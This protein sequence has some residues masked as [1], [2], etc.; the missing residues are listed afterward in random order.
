VAQ[1]RYG[2]LPEKVKQ[3]YKEIYP[4]QKFDFTK[5]K[6]GVPKE[7]KLNRSLKSIYQYYKTVPGY[8]PQLISNK[9]TLDS[10]KT[11]FDKAIKKGPVSYTDLQNQFPAQASPTLEKALGKDFKKLTRHTPV[12]TKIKPKVLKIV[13]EVYA[14]KRPLIDAAPSRLYQATYG[15]P[16][17]M[18]T[19][20]MGTISGILDESDKYDKMRSKIKATVGRVGGGNKLFNTVK[21]KDFDKADIRTELPRTSGN[22]VEEN[23]LRDLDRYI[24]RGGKDFKYTPDGRTNKFKTLKIKD[25]KKGDVL[26]YDRIKELIKKRDPRFKEYK[27]VFDNMK[28]LK[29]APYSDPIT[30]ETTTLLQGLQ[31]ATGIQAPLHIQHNKGILES[32]LKDLSISTHKANIGAKMVGSV[33]DIEKLGVRSTL[34]GGKK[35]YG[36]KL[37]FEDEVNRLTKFSDRMIKGGGT[38]TLKTPTQTLNEVKIAETI[39][40]GN[41]KIKK[42]LEARVGCAEG[43]LVKVANEEP[44]K[45]TRAL[46]SIKEFFVPTETIKYN[47]DI[48]AFE[49][50]NGDVATQEDLKLY[51]EENP[52]EVKVGEEPPKVNK[53][54][55]KTVGKTLA[56]VGAP[57]PTALLDSY[58]IGQQVKD[59]KSTEEIAKDPLNWIGLAAME[60]LSKVSGIA[61]SGGLNKALRLGLN[62]ATIRGISRF[63][64]LPGLAISTAMTAYD[65]YKKYQNEEGFVYNLFNK[66]G[67]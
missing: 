62:P 7:N 11:W 52:M 55:L 18:G 17:K 2:E 43:C 5:H 37:S 26:T 54:V 57:L 59:G 34:P 50:P 58:F 65:Q 9:K 3:W 22:L 48:G 40:V 33:E 6:Y 32:P 8:Y 64:G 53:S 14:N 35:V 45:I 63:A 61:E 46:N 66:E 20:N 21:L 28:R 25:L 10:I 12:T 67:N 44:G 47:N 13:D 38:R 29:L 31:K 27:K 15:K 19:S 30:K 36:P 4:N 51:A 23:I 24:S 56:K 42:A 60:P 49:T 39:N 41:P 1:S 16:Y